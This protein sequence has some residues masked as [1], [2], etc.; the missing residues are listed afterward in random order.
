MLIYVYSL[1]TKFPALKTN[2]VMLLAGSNVTITKDR[3][4]LLVKDSSNCIRKD[5]AIVLLNGD[6]S[7]LADTVY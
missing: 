2:R 7:S 5:S 1:M 6:N 3:T 4:V